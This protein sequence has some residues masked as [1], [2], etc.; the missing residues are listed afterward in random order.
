[1]IRRPDGDEETETSR[2]AGLG[3]HSPA[4][5]TALALFLLA[6]AGIP[7]TSGFVSKFAVFQTAAADGAGPLVVVGAISSVIAAFAYAR[8]IVTMFFHEP[9]AQTPAATPAPRLTTAVVAAAAAV[10]VIVGIAPQPLFDLIARAG[11]FRG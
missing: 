8:V 11:D 10:T 3:R 4:A 5:A 1:M 6:L 2:W 9:A 7:L